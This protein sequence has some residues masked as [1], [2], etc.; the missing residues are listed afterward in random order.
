WTEAVRRDYNHPCVVAWTP[1]NE[2]WGIRGVQD[3]V[4]QQ[5]FV[6]HIYNLTKRLDPYRPICDNSGW[7]HTL[8]DIADI[9][10][11]SERGEDLRAHWEEFERSNH[12]GGWPHLFF[13]R[14][15]SYMGQ[16]IVVSEYGGISLKGYEAP[17]GADRVAYGTH[18]ES[19]EAY[20]ARYRDITSAIQ[21]IE[22]LQGFCYTQLT[23]IEQEINGVMTYDRRPKVDPEKIAEINLRRR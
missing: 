15:K 6:E 14:A 22:E 4:A 18:M 10:D 1:F 2:S 9:H 16:P 17:A 13:A 3:G 5:Q 8:T 21:D 12:R 23:D 20:L 11:Y 19:E 7:M